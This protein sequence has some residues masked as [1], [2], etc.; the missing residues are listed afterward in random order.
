MPK[1]GAELAVTDLR[2]QA[3]DVSIHADLAIIGAGPAGVTIARELANTGIKIL[4]IESGGIQRDEETESLNRVENIGEPRHRPGVQAVGRG[5]DGNLAWLNQIPAFELRQRGLGGSTQTWIGKCATFDDIDFEKRDWMAESGWPF[6]RKSLEPHMDRAAALLNL[7]PNVYNENL[8][9]LLRTPPRQDVF[10]SRTLRPFFWQFSHER[11]ISGEPMRFS[12][13]ARSL[14]AANIDMLLNAT[15]T[16][17]ET[18]PNAR[19][20]KTIQARGINGAHASIHAKAV[21]LCCGAIENARLLLASNSSHPTGLGNQWDV[22]GRYLSDHPRTV[23]ARFTGKHLSAIAERFG[24][25]GLAARGNPRFYL[26]G[27]SLAPEFQRRMGLVNCAAYPVQILAEDDPWLAVKRATGS[28]GS[29]S[30]ADMVSILKSPHLL[31]AGAYNRLVRGRGIKRKI[32]ALR[33][34]VMAEQAPNPDSRVTLSDRRDRFGIAL[35]KVDWH[36]GELEIES[37]RQLGRQMA[38]TFQ[39]AGLPEPLLADWIVSGDNER[40]A[41]MD[42]AH[43]SGTTRM[44]SDPRRSVVD[45][46]CMVHGVDGLFVAGSSVFPTNGH[47][48]PTLMIIAMAMRLAD[49]LRERLSISPRKESLGPSTSVTAHSLSDATP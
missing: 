46:D 39:Q 27:L 48:N 34:D 29:F 4:L 12:R 2:E 13:F 31:L 17:I 45:S 15:V 10:A 36:I 44:G 11:D 6:S 26:H 43:P 32:S 19:S 40:I 30:G 41:F 49:H 7:G 38:A 5:Y 21:V 18:D 3:E 9:P 25:F 16:E 22:V 23:L 14:E 47:A 35:P 8:Y 33:F 28:S 24:F 42:M 20:V 1:G 37:I